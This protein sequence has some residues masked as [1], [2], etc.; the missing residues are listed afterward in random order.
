MKKNDLFTVLENIPFPDQDFMLRLRPQKQGLEGIRPGQFVNILIPE[1]AGVFLRRPISVCDADTGE[2]TLSLYVKKVGKGTKA[3][4]LCAP[5]D[6]LDILFPLGNGFNTEGVRHPLLL[7]GGAGIAPMIYLSKHLEAMHI[8]Y[9]VLLAGKTAA[10]VQ[11]R[12]CFPQAP[13]I[14]TDD[15]SLGEKG[16]ITQHSL[17]QQL[18]AYDKVFCCG[19]TPMMKAVARMSEATAVPCEVSLENTMA[20]GLGACLCCVTP[21]LE[22]GNV[23]VCTEGPVFDSR[24]LKDYR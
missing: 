2:Q 7:G 5:G 13:A 14:A 18:K 23:C 1:K 16:L 17:M 11:L 3:L 24:S 21:T 9:Q 15:G 6:T 8:P 4:A 12:E 10:S 19:P 22:N 20:C